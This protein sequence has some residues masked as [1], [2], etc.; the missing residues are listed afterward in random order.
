MRQTQDQKRF[1]ILE[2]A[3]DWHELMI[4]QRTIRPSIARVNKQLDPI[5]P[6]FADDI[7]AIAVDKDEHMIC[8]TL[9][10]GVDGV[11]VWSKKWGMVL[12]VEKIKLMMFGEPITGSIDVFIDG[13]KIEVVNQMKYLGM[14]LERSRRTA[15][16][17]CA[18][19]RHDDLQHEV[20]TKGLQEVDMAI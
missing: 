3:A 15:A 14:W 7:V 17:I 2:V 20:P 6:K 8:Q 1:T 16:R 18:R 12:N 13:V 10:R 9:Q 4:P 11:V 5:Y 19:T